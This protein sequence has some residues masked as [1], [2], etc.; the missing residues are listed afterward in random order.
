MRGNFFYKKIGKRII[1][2]R[3]NRQLSQEKLAFESYVD[4]TYLSRIEDGKAN[5]TVKVIH[6]IARGLRMKVCELMDGV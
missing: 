3:K 2:E 6:K 4:R 1:T 5:P